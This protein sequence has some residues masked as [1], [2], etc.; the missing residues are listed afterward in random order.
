MTG[1]SEAKAKAPPESVGLGYCSDPIRDADPRKLWK[2][3]R[4][5][6]SRPQVF[7]PVTDVEALYVDG[8]G[9]GYT[10]RTMT[11]VGPGPMNGLVIKENIY[12]EEST[13]EIRFVVLDDDGKETDVEI[14]NALLDH[15]TRIE[16]Y[17][18]A[19]GTRERLEWP[20]PKASAVGAIKKTVELAREDV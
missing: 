10:R 8:D 1:D 14:V 5:K 15:P 12:A 18:R 13:G 9:G 17:R 16:Y 19:V 11:F 6:I 7:L 3:M 2:H 20:A 4:T